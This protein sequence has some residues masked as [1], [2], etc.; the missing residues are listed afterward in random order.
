MWCLHGKNNKSFRSEDSIIF[1]APL[2]GPVLKAVV[3][4]HKP[5]TELLSP[6]SSNASTTASTCSWP[7]EP[8][9]CGIEKSLHSFPDEIITGRRSTKDLPV[10][11][12]KSVPSQ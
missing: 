11:S 12:G 1:P 4:Q 5:T 10:T 9:S 3:S 6:Y 7:V 8:L 2:F